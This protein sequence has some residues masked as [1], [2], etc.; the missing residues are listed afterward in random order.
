[1][2][3]ILPEYDPAERGQQADRLAT[4]MDS[5]AHGVSCLV[6]SLLNEAICTARGI[7]PRLMHT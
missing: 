3:I 1:E 5:L 2:T 6:E 7:F 4:L